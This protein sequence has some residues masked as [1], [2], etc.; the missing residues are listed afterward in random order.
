[1]TM[2]DSRNSL[3]GAVVD[4][5]KP[6]LAAADEECARCGRKPT[7]YSDFRGWD[8]DLSTDEAVC[9]ECTGR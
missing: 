2:H 7:D 6:P 5:R 1:M 3:R 8:L 4:A 9:P